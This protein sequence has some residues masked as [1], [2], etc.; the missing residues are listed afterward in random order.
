MKEWHLGGR[1][2]LPAENEGDGLTRDY[3]VADILEASTA[4][5]LSLRE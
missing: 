5:C 4:F 2:N 1:P 3:E